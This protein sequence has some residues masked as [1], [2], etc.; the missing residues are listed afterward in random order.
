[1]SLVRG[2][3]TIQIGKKRVKIKKTMTE[4]KWPV[5]L[6]GL[7][8]PNDV[9]LKYLMT[10][11]RRCSVHSRL[12]RRLLLFRCSGRAMLRINDLMPRRLLVYC[13]CIIIIYCYY[14]TATDTKRFCI[15]FCLCYYDDDI[16]VQY[17]PDRLIEELTY[18]LLS[19]RVMYLCLV[20][21]YTILYSGYGGDWTHLEL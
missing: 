1:M 6:D 4:N 5:R 16:D 13:Y 11:P 17:S 3:L 18:Q 9:T 20:S 8:W 19:P 14:F 7:C 10:R 15:H 21:L 12:T 2:L